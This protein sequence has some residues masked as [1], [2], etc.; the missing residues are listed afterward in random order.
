[1]RS[2][3]MPIRPNFRSRSRTCP[4]KTPRPAASPRSPS[5]PRYASLTRRCGW[6]PDAPHAWCRREAAWYT[7]EMTREQVKEVLDRVLTW[8]AERQADAAHMLELM[9]EQDKSEP[10]LSD[11]QI[12]EVK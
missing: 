4:R 5:S 1:M 10:W 6:E 11:E 2:R 7:V 3:S 8:P 12:A 9:E